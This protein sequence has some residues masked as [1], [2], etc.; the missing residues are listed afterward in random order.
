[1]VASAETACPARALLLW[2]GQTTTKNRLA[3]AELGASLAA[4]LS[5]VEVE[6]PPTGTG[7]R[8]LL[9]LPQLI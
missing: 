4:A 7:T 5:L 6:A 8:L 9:Q 2:A 3:C 1:M